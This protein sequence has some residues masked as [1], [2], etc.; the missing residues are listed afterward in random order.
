MFALWAG[1]TRFVFDTIHKLPT[2]TAQHSLVVRIHATKGV[3]CQFFMALVTCPEAATSIALICDHITW[4]MI[5]PTTSL[6]INRNT[7][8]F[9]FLHTLLKPTT[10]PNRS[11]ETSWVA[12]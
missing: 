1:E 6:R 8:D 7:M 11:L 4:R 9:D 12:W 5:V 10:F 2:I 3:T